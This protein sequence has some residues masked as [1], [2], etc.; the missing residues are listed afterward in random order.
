MAE[1]KCCLRMSLLGVPTLK[2]HNHYL[3]LHKQKGSAEVPHSNVLR[4]M[5]KRHEIHK[6]LTTQAL[7]T[8]TAIHIISAHIMIR[9]ISAATLIFRRPSRGVKVFRVTH[10]LQK[11]ATPVPDTVQQ[12]NCALYRDDMPCHNLNSVPGNLYLIT[13]NNVIH[14]K[15]HICSGIL[16]KHVKTKEA[17][18]ACLKQISFP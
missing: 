11:C 4:E 7:C 14:A 15:A 13:V 16:K 1:A 5:Y 12:T 2:R 8:F 17:P 18:W 6:S 3:C 10:A 9:S